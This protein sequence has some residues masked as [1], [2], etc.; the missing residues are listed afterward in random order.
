MTLSPDHIL[1]LCVCAFA[2][3]LTSRWL[4]KYGVPQL[5]RVLVAA[6]VGVTVVELITLAELGVFAL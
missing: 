5:G 1:L 6:C 2:G 3:W 4:K